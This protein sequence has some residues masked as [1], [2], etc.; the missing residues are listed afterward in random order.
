MK[1]ILTI[2]S[3]IGLLC[4]HACYEDKGNYNYIEVKPAELN[5]IEKRYTLISF[6][7]TLKIAPKVI[8]QNPGDRFSYI[9]TLNSTTETEIK[10]EEVDT[11]G[12]LPKLIF[13]IELKT[14]S[15]EIYLTV[16]NEDTGL[17]AFFRSDLDVVTKYSRGFY[18]LKELNGTT[19]IDGY[20]ADEQ[21]ERN[22]I[23]SKRGSAMQ[24]TPMSLGVTFKYAYVN[25]II[26]GYEVTTTLNVC[27]EKEICILN[28]Q[29]MSKIYDHNDMFFGET[30]DEHPLYLF[31]NMFGVAFLSDKG[32]Y[33]SYQA[34]DYGMNGSGKFG[35]PT[36]VEGGCSPN[37][38]VAHDGTATYLFDD[39]NNRFLACDWN[40]ALHT[41]S[42]VDGDGKPKKF[43]PRD[44]PYRLEFFGRNYLASQNTGYAL[45]EDKIDNSQHYLYCLT[46]K[47]NKFHNPIDT[48]INIESKFKI[49]GATRFANNK[50]DAHILYFIADNKL[51]M[52]DIKQGKEEELVP[53]GLNRSEE[54]IYIDNCYWTQ[55]DD[56][57]H[58][59]NYLAIGTLQNGNYKIYLYETLGGKPYG[60]AKRILQGEGIPYKLQYLSPKMTGSSGE[61]YSL[62]F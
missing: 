7:D 45:F 31:S 12:T 33:F 53:M 48:V 40:G 59:F 35:F 11:I 42:D 57:D 24:G 17:Q 14:G 5:D 44:I 58:N 20:F 23:E 26:S 29:D 55:N 43:L 8:S 16:T 3:L 1:R 19:E 6:Q 52:Y 18:V 46:L 38:H 54:I 37:I 22:L 34:P 21:I 47:N 25:P 49:N 15:Y 30:P 39:K 4:C 60:E 10:L 28:V 56:K 61:F 2:L 36:V 62:S 27:S 50:L 32:Y 51:Y 41:Y 13:P 9:W